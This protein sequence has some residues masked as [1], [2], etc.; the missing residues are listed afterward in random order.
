VARSYGKVLASIWGDPDFVA[1]HVG[2]Q[3]LYMLLCSQARLTLAGSLDLM[4][5]RWATLAAGTSAADIDTDLDELASA[6][7]VVVDRDTEELVIRTLV[8]HDLDN[9]RLNNNLIKGLW[10]AW[11]GILSAPLRRV[12]VE[13][14]P[15]VVWERSGTSAP[16]EAQQMRR[17]PRLEPAVPTNGSDQPSEP[18]VSC[19]LSPV[20]GLLSPA[21]AA[22]RDPRGLPP[23]PD[24]SQAAAQ[25][26]DQDHQPAVTQDQRQ[27]RLHEAIELLVDRELERN[28]TR[29]GSI[30]RHRNGVRNGKLTDHTQQ[31]HRYLHLNPNLT[32][33][34]L[35]DLLEPPPPAPAPA[36]AEPARRTAD[37]QPFIPSVGV[38]TGPAVLGE[39]PDPDTHQALMAN[40]WSALR[41]EPT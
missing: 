9:N 23:D 24:P 15:E 33:R 5:T 22:E 25:D 12:V 4:P 40:A 18:P 29:G 27:Q 35:A 38:A 31:A 26:Q 37:G 20:S 17:S 1:L 21:A 28:P 39:E 19:L 30:D 16:T 10:A 2:P 32:A 41:P 6:R 7:F 14:L 11:A 3:R 13:N 36:R 34:A 8:R